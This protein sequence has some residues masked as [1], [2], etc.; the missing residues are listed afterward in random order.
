MSSNTGTRGGKRKE[1]AGATSLTLGPTH[2]GPTHPT[3]LERPHLNRPR[4][5]RPP[6]KPNKTSI[7]LSLETLNPKTSLTQY[8][9]CVWEEWI[10]N[11]GAAWCMRYTSWR[12][13][14]LRGARRLCWIVLDCVG[15]CWIVLDWID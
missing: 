15:L 10:A 3:H 11:P 1:A 14:K 4:L 2:L 9:P 7:T 6:L 12:A 13:P 8:V 5:R